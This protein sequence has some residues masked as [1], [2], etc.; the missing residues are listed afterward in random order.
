[1]NDLIPSFFKKFDEEIKKG[2]DLLPSF[3]MAKSI[4]K[5]HQ[6]MLRELQEQKDN[7]KSANKI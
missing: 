5:E 4:N 2:L 7:E 6:K 1:M 3:A